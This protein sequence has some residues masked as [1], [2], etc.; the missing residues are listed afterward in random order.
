MALVTMS[1]AASEPCPGRYCGRE[2]VDGV[3]SERCGACPRA[4]RSDGTLCRPCSR[5]LNTYEIFFLGFM[6]GLKVFLEVLS[7]H[8]DLDDAGKHVWTPNMRLFGLSIAVETVLALVI[9]IVLVE[10]VGSFEVTSCGMRQVS[11]WYP[12]LH[13]PRPDY[14]ATIYCSNEAAYPLVTFPLIFYAFSLIMLF[15]VRVGI[16]RRWADANCKA[17]T[18]PACPQMLES[19]ES[20]TY[21]HVL[22]RLGSHPLSISFKV[23]LQHTF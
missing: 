4:H 19:V 22:E 14:K 21:S 20:D 8:H 6:I 1:Y 10:P 3:V 5:T 11:D 7:V 12:Y 16:T 18:M 13:N 9:T 15:A 17:D 2:V 23:G